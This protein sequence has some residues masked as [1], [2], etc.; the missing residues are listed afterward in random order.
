MERTSK[1]LLI[2]GL[3]LLLV[4]GVSYGVGLVGVKK[5]L[6][7]EQ[8]VEIFSLNFKELVLKIYVRLKNPT[9]TKFTIDHPFVKLQYKGTTIGSSQVSNVTYPIEGK[10]EFPL[11]PI[12]LS[13]SLLGLG[14]TA[15]AFLKE[16]R[17][18]GTAVITAI[19]ST[20]I[21]G[22]IK[23]E[24]TKQITLGTAREEIQA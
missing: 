1:L 7:I 24:D 18:K 8:E 4:T 11:K 10:S 2:G 13:I 20:K 5:E 14:L 22:N 6:E 12:Y 9:S 21:D 19:T 3:A 16:I 23:V 15:P 17:T